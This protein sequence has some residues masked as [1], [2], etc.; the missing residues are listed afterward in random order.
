MSAETDERNENDDELDEEREEGERE[1]TSQ[2]AAAAP[3]EKKLLE[4]KWLK[5]PT[6]AQLEWKRPRN[7]IIYQMCADVGKNLQEFRRKHCPTNTANQVAMANYNRVLK[8]VEHSL[9]LVKLTDASKFDWEAISKAKVVLPTADQSLRK[10]IKQAKIDI[11]NER[12]EEQQHSSGKRPFQGGNG[13]SGATR[14]TYYWNSN[15]GG[16]RQSNNR[17]PNSGIDQKSARSDKCYTCHKSSHYSWNC[18]NRDKTG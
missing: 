12:K 9:G 15:R 18:P 17:S 5:I 2:A 8:S 14:A 3:K 13:G 1:P 4:F 7:K 16:A 6:V 11:L 10:S